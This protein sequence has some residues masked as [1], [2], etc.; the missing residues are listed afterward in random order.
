MKLLMMLALPLPSYP[1]LGLWPRLPSYLMTYGARRTDRGQDDRTDRGQDGIGCLNALLT[2]NNHQ[3]KWSRKQMYSK[4]NIY[5][6]AR[7]AE[8]HKINTHICFFYFNKNWISPVSIHTDGQYASVSI[9][10]ACFHFSSSI[11]SHTYYQV[12]PY[13]WSPFLAPV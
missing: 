9:Y 4:P 7:P 6:T 3:T 1:T 5:W 11:G 10:D 13:S 12:Y 8:W 2:T